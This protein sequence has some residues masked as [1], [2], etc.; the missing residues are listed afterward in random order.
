MSER[1]FAFI[2][3]TSTDREAVTLTTLEQ[4][5]DLADAGYE[6]NVYLDGPATQWAEHVTNDDDSPVGEYLTEAVERGLLVGACG[7]CTVKFDSVDKLRGADIEQ[8][9]DGTEHGIDAA[10]LASEGFELSFVS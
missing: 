10:R 9:G 4:V 6:T 2:L 7:L 8:F 3:K 5:L 1:K